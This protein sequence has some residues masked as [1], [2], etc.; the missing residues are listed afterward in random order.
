[1][2]NRDELQD[3]FSRRAEELAVAQGWQ[4]PGRYAQRHYKLALQEASAEERSV[5]RGMTGGRERGQPERAATHQNQLAAAYIKT[6][7]AKSLRDAV[8][9][10]DAA[11][12]N[13]A[14]KAG[15][16]TLGTADAEGAQHYSLVTG[17]APRKYDEVGTDLLGQPVRRSPKMSD[18]ETK[19]AALSETD[20]L[21]LLVEKPG[22]GELV[23]WRGFLRS[24]AAV[25]T[26]RM[27]AGTA[28]GGP[29]SDPINA[30]IERVWQA[31]RQERL[32]RHGY[33]D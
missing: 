22:P 7:R 13:I 6:G 29:Q 19:L 28:P 12:P 10:A 30:L 3:R 21:E 26:P 14:T 17:S 27:P 5:E 25:V 23:N 15:A 8:K 2:P 33:T 31:A 4:G 16:R 20:V 24:W 1:M 11:A 9:M 18:S 32:R